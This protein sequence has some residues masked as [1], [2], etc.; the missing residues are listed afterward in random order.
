MW[1][2]LAAALSALL[3]VVQIS[4]AQRPGNGGSPFVPYTSAG[5][6]SEFGAPFVPVNAS[7]SGGGGGFVGP[8]DVVSGAT[9]WFGFR[10]YSAARA[11]AQFHAVNVTNAA[12]TET[13]DIK[14]TTAGGL[15]S[16]VSACSGASSGATVATFCTTSCSIAKFYDQS[17]NLTDATQ[18]T[19]ANQPPFVLSCINGLPCMG[20]DG[21]AKSLQAVIANTASPYSTST[22]YNH[23]NATALSRPIMT[24]NF[25]SGF[26]LISGS[27]AN[28][29][30]GEQAGAFFTAAATDNVIHSIGTIF[31]GASSGFYVDGAWTP[32]TTTAQSTGTFL[33]LSGTNIAN[34]GELGLWPVALTGTSSGNALQTNT[35]CL[36]QFAYYGLGVCGGY[37]GPGD[38]VP[39]AMAWYGLRAYSAAKAIAQAPAANVTNSTNTETCDIKLATTGGLAA[40]VANCSGASSGTVIAT[41]CAG[42]CRIGTLYDQSGNGLNATQATFANQIPLV[43]SCIS[44]L[45]CFST[46][47]ASQFLNATITSQAS[48]YSVSMVYDRTNSA[49]TNIPIFATGS[50]FQVTSGP[51]ANTIQAAQSTSLFTAAATDNANH[52]IATILNGASSGFYIDGTWTPGSTVAVASNTAL[53]IASAIGTTD[54]NNMGEVGL[55]PAAFT[56]TSSANALQTNALCHNQFAYWGTATSC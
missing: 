18:A 40:T 27:S 2:T 37:V 38:L 46:T 29:V 11:A 22:V 1:R 32:G 3:L 36:N 55:W 33:V 12:G 48:P 31:N 39:G 21:N 17:A 25:G 49:S 50:G 30:Q 42:G 24:S 7:C 23:T 54:T 28:Q 47:G 10:A 51:S 43:L 15:S 44:A 19:V 16:T 45:P 20:E 34:V 41:F 35:L 6:G 13:C 52:S 5:C 4:Y 9:A 14:L 8:G 26:E 56:G 53:A